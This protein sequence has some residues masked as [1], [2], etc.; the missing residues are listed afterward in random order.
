MTLTLDERFVLAHAAEIVWPRLS[1]IAFVAD[2]FPGATLDGTLPDGGHSGSLSMRL[3]PTKAR[4]AGTVH[5]NLDHHGRV[6]QL[7]AEGSDSRRSMAAAD[8]SVRLE[9]IDATT[10]AVVLD[11]AI[12]ISGPL[13]QFARAGGVQVTRTLLADFI[14]HVECRLAEES[15]D[16][17][18]D[19]HEAAASGTFHVAATGCRSVGRSRPS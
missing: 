1:D 13:G 15:A 18:S 2:C 4:F 16:V 19:G 9:S 11:V 6:A 17:R 5:V 3:G 12:E 10:S 8:A 14:T 7:H